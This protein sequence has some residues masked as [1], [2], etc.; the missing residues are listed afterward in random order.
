MPAGPT[1]I[2]LRFSSMKDKVKRF[3]TLSRSSSLGHDQWFNDFAKPN[4]YF[5]SAGEIDT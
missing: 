3:S 4:L 5:G 2:A 1:K